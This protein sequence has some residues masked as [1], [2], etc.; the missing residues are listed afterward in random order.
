MG[1]LYWLIFSVLVL[2]LFLFVDQYAVDLFFNDQWSYL[3][4][5]LFPSSLAE[6]FFTPLGPHRIGLGYYF[7]KGVLSISDY[8]N[9]SIALMVAGFISLNAG[10]FTWLKGRMIGSLQLTDVFIPLIFFNLHQYAIV[11]NNPNISIHQL[12][13][14]ILLLLLILF[15]HGMSKTRFLILLFAIPIISFT[16][17][18]FFVGIALVIFT[19]LMGLKQPTKK[20]WWWAATLTAFVSSGL[21]LFSANYA[22]MDCGSSLSGSAGYY[23]QFLRG[24][25]LNGLLISSPGSIFKT[26]L[27][28]ILVVIALWSTAV[29]LI[30][31]KD[32]Q[33]LAPMLIILYVLLFIAATT[34]GRWCFGL[35]ITESSRYVPQIAMGFLAFAL[36][37]GNNRAWAYN[38]F[39]V[40]LT[41]M[42]LYGIPKFYRWKEPV[43]QTYSQNMNHWKDCYVKHG[44]APFCNDTLQF[45]PYPGDIGPI[46][47]EGKLR[48]LE[49]LNPTFV[50]VRKRP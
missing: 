34:L 13:F 39:S 48:H 3:T 31:Y 47:L 43:V 19:L 20:Y 46:K 50:G 35:P 11:L 17:N 6:G 7:F 9:R 30:R 49:K 36:W 25:V 18:G 10:I 21:Y 26:A 37:T 45:Q 14:T 42:Y 44:N 41:L 12:I 28:L 27:S 32:E 16:G 23:F 4:T 22:A 2:R 8:N 5:S 29:K 24:M 1:G 38:I 40:F 33:R 15:C